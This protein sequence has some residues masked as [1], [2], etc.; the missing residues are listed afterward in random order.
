MKDNKIYTY[1]VAGV[2]EAMKV[3]ENDNGVYTQLVITPLGCNKKMSFF[4]SKMYK[5]GK[6][7]PVFKKLAKISCGDTITVNYSILNSSFFV[8]D[9]WRLSK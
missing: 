1:D 3:R 9:A 7:N 6:E 8:F 4:V 2:V 5:N